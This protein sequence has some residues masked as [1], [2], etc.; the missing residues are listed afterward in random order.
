MMMIPRT[1]RRQC[2]D[3]LPFGYDSFSKP[4]S[5]VLVLVMQVMSGEW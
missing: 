3:F 4:L 1:W 5:L 2:V